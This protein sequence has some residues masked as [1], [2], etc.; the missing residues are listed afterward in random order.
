IVTPEGKRVLVDAGPAA[1]PVVPYLRSHHYDTLDLVVASHN[2]TDHIGGM[3]AVI[4]ST[5]MRAYLDNGIPHTTATYESTVRAVAA[6]GA[7]SLQATARTIAVGSARL[8]VLPP[9][10]RQGDQ[11][12]GSVGILLEYGAFRALLTGDSEQD[13]LDY[14]L[15]HDSVPRVTVVKVAH[16]GSQNGTTA[17]WVQATGPQDAVISVGA[18]HAYGHPAPQVI[19]RAV[20]V[21]VGD[22]GVGLD[23]LKKTLPVKVREGVV[24]R[25]RLDAAGNP[26]WS[27]ATIDDAERERRLQEARERLERLRGTDPGGDVVL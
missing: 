8:R 6:S 9:P 15:K 16:H 3:T 27:S 5:T 4:A 11:N 7:Q 23:V 1:F 22:D 12:N 25:V 26:D 10:A 2:H 14:W 18:G 13:E 17:A 20:A 24:L 19:E 21:L